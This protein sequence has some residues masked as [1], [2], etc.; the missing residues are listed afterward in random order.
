MEKLT[1]KVFWKNVNG[2][3]DQIKGYV[4][5][6]C[7]EFNLYCAN[8][9]I[10]EEGNTTFDTYSKISYEELVSSLVREKYPINEEFAILRKAFNNPYN[11]EFIVY[12]EYVEE[13][14]VEAKK[15]IQEREIYIK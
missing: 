15:F 3:V 2:T 14:K 1:N 11:D 5:R 6:Y 10:D 4:A 9:E 7:S 13:C 12:N 8:L